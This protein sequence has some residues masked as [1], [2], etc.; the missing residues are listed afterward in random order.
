MDRQNAAAAGNLLRLSLLLALILAGGLWLAMATTRD[1]LQVELQGTARDGANT[2]ALALRPYLIE[3]NTLSLETA[4]TALV[5]GGHYQAIAVRSAPGEVLV[6]RRSP[7]LHSPVPQWFSDWVAI[8]APVAVATIDRGW[9]P[10]GQ[11]QVSIHPAPAQQ[12]L[13]RLARGFAG[14]AL[15]GLAMVLLLAWPR[16]GLPGT[17]RSGARPMAAPGSRRDF[18]RA[19][20]DSTQ[21]ASRAGGEFWLVLDTGS[22]AT[23]DGAIRQ[24]TNGDLPELL[25]AHL[26]AWVP[27]VRLYQLS[28]HEFALN[29]SHSHHAAA[30]GLAGWLCAA[31]GSVLRGNEEGSKPVRSNRNTSGLRVTVVPVPASINLRA[32]VERC[33]WAFAQARQ[34]EAFQWCVYGAHSG[35]SDIPVLKVK[36][37][38]AA[39]PPV[40][41]AADKDKGPDKK[42]ASKP[43]QNEPA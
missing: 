9:Q 42:A 17:R 36:V 32:A 6:E 15:A 13:W 31:L 40:P 38:R 12:Q 14:L 27:T 1:Y 41:F 37:R 11:V 33:N 8:E 29:L 3:D 30:C 26:E 19:L 25:R 35:A 20:R 18:I 22:G 16:I 39:A 28:P 34:L 5:Q 43:R 7:A 10:V 24:W 4:V 2:L 23:P 21:R